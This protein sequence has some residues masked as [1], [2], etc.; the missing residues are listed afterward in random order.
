MVQELNCSVK[1]V[2]L[3]F[4]VF[5]EEVG[6]NFPCG[7][8]INQVQEIKAELDQLVV[9]KNFNMGLRAS[10]NDREQGGK[11]AR[12]L[13]MCMCMPFKLKRLAITSPQA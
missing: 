7:S 2:E 6:K 1:I 3:D 8:Y 4:V 11:V 9:M 5:M 10:H 12:A 13:H